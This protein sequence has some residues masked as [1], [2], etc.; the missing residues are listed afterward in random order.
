MNT[1]AKKALVFAGITSATIAQGAV[2]IV[3]ADIDQYKQKTD[4]TFYDMYQNPNSPIAKGA[5]PA[6]KALISNVKTGNK[7]AYGNT[8][9]K[10]IQGS[11]QGTPIK[12]GTTARGYVQGIGTLT[13]QVDDQG[14]VKVYGPYTNSNHTE[15]I[16]EGNNAIPISS[17]RCLK[18]QTYNFGK[19]SR[20]ACTLYQREAVEE[21][22][23]AINGNFTQRKV[24]QNATQ[25]C[26]PHRTGKYTGYITCNRRGFNTVNVLSVKNQNINIANI[27]K[28]KQKLAINV[29]EKQISYQGEFAN[30]VDNSPYVR[31][32]KYHLR[33]IDN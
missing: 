22:F 30:K 9:G 28:G 24:L 13:F 5:N 33:M 12:V 10:V 19:V 8:I 16:R 6:L 31:K 1:K 7:F 3:P 21:V 14:N 26:Q 15:A 27:L 4:Q 17:T 18:T 11:V 25:T 20:T 23:N 29:D 32:I 2:Y